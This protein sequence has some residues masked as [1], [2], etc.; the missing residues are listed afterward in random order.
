MCYKIDP[1]LPIKGSGSRT[2]NPD[3]PMFATFG[4][5]AAEVE[6]DL[7]TGEVTLVK[8][9][10]AHDFGK[11]INPKLCVSQVYGGIEFGVGYALMEEGIFDPRTGKML[12]SNLHH[13]RMPTSLDF[14]PV[15]VFLFES[16]NPW[17]AYSAKGGA[18]VTN[19]PTPA[20]IGNAVAHALDGVWINDLPMMPDKII[21]AIRNK[22]E[23][24]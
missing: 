22:N 5:Q 11:A 20:A 14:P 3:D 6:V 7:E 10:A 13:Y 23:R 19:T 4:A 2:T 8:M 15:N 24:G 9:T 16:E 21:Q 17:F 1:Q 12:N 18:E